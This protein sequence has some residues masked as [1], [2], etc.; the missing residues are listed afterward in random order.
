MLNTAQLKA[1]DDILNRH[2]NI[3]E[4]GIKVDKKGCTLIFKG[5][6]YHIDNK[7]YVSRGFWDKGLP[8]PIKVIDMVEVKSLVP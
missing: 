4:Y 5:Y 6:R 7:G 2:D 3:E 1:I 8:D